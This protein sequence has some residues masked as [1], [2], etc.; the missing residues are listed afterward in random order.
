MKK[1]AVLLSLLLLA[2]CAGCSN[3][4]EEALALTPDPVLSESRYT[5]GDK[6]GDYTITDVNGVSHNF[7]EILAEKKAIVLNF[8]FIN[9]GPCRIEF[10]Y[11]NE[12]Y[13]SLKADIEILAINPTGESEEDIKA[14]S[15]EMGLT[16]P[17][18]V[19]DLEW[20]NAFY[21][22]GFP[23]TV[24]I[25]RTGT[26]SFMHTGYID[27]TETFMDIFEFFI[28]EDYTPTVV[29]NISDIK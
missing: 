11:M 3:N 15:E 28:S 8:W 20:N 18:A 29:K 5:L 24:V 13:E 1:I 7:S 21:I 10:P 23:T 26:I 6:M 19:G 9:C 2:F 12:A 14:F 25:D 22:Q 17:V 27:S 4:S 16:F